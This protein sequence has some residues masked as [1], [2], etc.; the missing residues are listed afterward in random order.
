MLKRFEGS[1]CAICLHDGY[2]SAAV[3]DEEGFVGKTKGSESVEAI[4]VLTGI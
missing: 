3:S 4:T 2:E 1:C